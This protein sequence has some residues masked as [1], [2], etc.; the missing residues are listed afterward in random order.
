MAFVMWQIIALE[1][2]PDLR[3]GKLDAGEADGDVLRTPVL[4]DED[5]VC[6][7]LHQPQR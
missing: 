2:Y 7:L 5:L 6:L 4:D 1:V 3:E